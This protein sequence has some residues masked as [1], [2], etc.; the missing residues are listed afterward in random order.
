MTSVC[1]CVCASV[2]LQYRKEM[3]R[4]REVAGDRGSRLAESMATVVRIENF[5]VEVRVIAHI[6]V[7]SCVWIYWVV[8]RVFICL[9]LV[10]M[11]GLC[12]CV[13][14]CV[15]VARIT[16][17]FGFRM[18]WQSHFVCVFVCIYM[19]ACICAYVCMYVIVCVSC[20]MYACVYVC[21]HLCVRVHFLFLDNSHVYTLKNFPVFLHVTVCS[22]VC[23]YVLSSYISLLPAIHN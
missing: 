10:G 20:C 16:A 5:L 4:W 12:M 3:S 18:Y 11:R 8:S 21:M 2:S 17:R 7:L 23:V 6:L 15:P 14:V 13:R 9:Y 19:Y 1:V 22:Y